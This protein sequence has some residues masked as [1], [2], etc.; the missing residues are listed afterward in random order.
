MLGVGFA[1]CLR[2]HLMATSDV[3]LTGEVAIVQ[4]N[5]DGVIK[6]Y[7]MEGKDY[8]KTMPNGAES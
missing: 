4:R 2:L 3:K 1:M 6:L 7:L 5:T 8:Y